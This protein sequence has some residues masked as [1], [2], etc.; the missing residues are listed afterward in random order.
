MVY[1]Q[2]AV[3]LEEGELEEG[4]LDDDSVDVK[5]EKARA[6]NPIDYR[7][8][9]RK[10]KVALLIA[11]SGGGFHGMQKNPDVETIELR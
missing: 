1:L 10:R 8:F 11:Y 4:E 2:E 9:N 6:L 7:H 5:P 3:E